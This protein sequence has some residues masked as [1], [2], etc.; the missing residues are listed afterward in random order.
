MD[1]LVLEEVSKKIGSRRIVNNVSMRVREGEVYGFLGP[2]GAGK[3]TT[4]R[5]IVGLIQPTR[6]T[7]RIMG[8][9]VQKR[10]AQAMAHIGTIVENPETYSY[11]SG[12]KNLIHYARLAGLSKKERDRRVEEVTELVRLTDRI[13]DK[14]KTYSLGMR[15]RLG[16]AQALL[17]NPRLL[18]LDEPTNGLD[19]AGIREF[20]DLIRRLADDGMA[21]FVS[22]HLLSEIQMMCDRV[23]ILNHG[24]LLRE[25]DVSELLE[26]AA[27]VSFRVRDSA[28]ALQVFQREGVKA[29]E[30]EHGIIYTYLEE[31]AIPEMV[32][33]LVYQDVAIYSVQ[34]QKNSLEETF[35]QLTEKPGVEEG[36]G[37]GVGA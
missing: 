13:D 21:V 24:R 22:S 34:L 37:G 25:A 33:R 14:V 26:Q 9:D 2:N 35:L 6:G 32:K 23:A 17:A 11:L 29:K 30:G 12:R 7:I 5:M 4:I 15:Q 19:P 27:S 18:V 8:H 36:K 16:V 28:Y 1:V 10:P 20:R 31:E 3:T